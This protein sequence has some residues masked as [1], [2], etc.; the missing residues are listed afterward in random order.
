MASL[1]LPP[2]RLMST[3]RIPKPFIVAMCIM[4]VNTMRKTLFVSERIMA[5]ICTYVGDYDESV[6]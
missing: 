6:L 5:K 2:V 3:T 1:K 4:M